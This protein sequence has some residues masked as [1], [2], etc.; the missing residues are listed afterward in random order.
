MSIGTKPEQALER[1]FNYQPLTEGQIKFYEEQGYLLL[2]QTLREEGLALFREQCR[3][4]WNAEK[5]AFDDQA[6]WLK[7]SLLINIHHKSSLVRDFYFQGPLVDVAE[8]LI[9]PN[10]K[11]ATS[12]LTFKMRGN[13]QPFAWHQDNGYGQL[14]PYNALSTLTAMDDA[15]ERN[16]CLWLVPASHREG[17]IMVNRSEK[18]IAERIAIE[19]EVDENL[20]SPMPMKAG[21]SLIF[22]CW[23]L[24]KSDGNFSKDRDPRILYLRYADADAVEVHNDNQPRLGRLVRGQTKFDQVR[25]F[26]QEL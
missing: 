26:E 4:A 20:A 1:Y 7:N 6:S 22:N 3:E 16:G 8:Q 2:S 5:T 9:G 13:I 19:L 17:Q 18:E 25:K 21:D 23:M 11:C 10:I 12:Q 14:D 24:H 15:D